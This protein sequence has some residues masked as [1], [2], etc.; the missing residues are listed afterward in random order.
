[1]NRPSWAELVRVFLPIGLLGFGGPQAHMA[2]MR[3]QVVQQRQWVSAQAFAEGVAL[4]EALPGPASSQL[5]MVLGWRWR[6]AWGGLVSGFCFLLPGPGF[7]Y[8]A[9]V[10]NSDQ[11]DAPQQL[12]HDHGTGQARSHEDQI[13]GNAHGVL[14]QNSIPI[15]GGCSPT[16]QSW[17]YSWPLSRQAS[18][19]CNSRP[20]YRAWSRRPTGHGSASSTRRMPTSLAEHPR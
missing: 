13:K 18:A 12:E 7:G 9:S 5:A 8:D 15:L 20:R 6:G 19:R 14:R 4:C 17:T 10:L 2:L 16:P 11:L 1:M 3:E